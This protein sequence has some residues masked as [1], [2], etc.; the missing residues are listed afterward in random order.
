MLIPAETNCRLRK[1]AAV[2]IQNKKFIS[3][4]WKSA[5][6]RKKII[7]RTNMINVSRY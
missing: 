3:Q 5:R 4:K 7:G 2:P 6:K 1:Q